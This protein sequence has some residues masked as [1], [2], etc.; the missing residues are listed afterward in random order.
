MHEIRR[1][2]CL[3][4]VANQA[5]ITARNMSGAFPR[6]Q[7]VVMTT[8]AGTNDLIVIDPDQIAPS[9]GPVTVLTQIACGEMALPLAIRGRT[10]MAAGAIVGDIVMLEIGRNPDIGGVTHIA[11]LSRLD[12]P[13]RHTARTGNRTVVTTAAGADH[14][15]M[16]HL[17]QGFPLTITM[18]ILANIQGRNVVTVFARD[19]E[20][21]MTTEAILSND[22]VSEVR[23]CPAIGRMAIGT[24]IATDDMPGA[25]A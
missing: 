8:D 19:S 11:L 22:I 14:I 5:V 9:S 4:R 10:V 16:V 25:L 6:Q 2:P 17:T 21:I 12:M 18:T 7:G 1:F 3:G 23:R 13:V 20:T 24:S 15:C